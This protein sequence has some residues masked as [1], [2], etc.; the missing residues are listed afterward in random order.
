M[1]NDSDSDDGT[2]KSGNSGDSQRTYD[3]GETANSGGYLFDDPLG[4]MRE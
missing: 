2:A 3:S 4:K 1:L